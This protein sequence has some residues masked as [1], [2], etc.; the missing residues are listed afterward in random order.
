[1]VDRITKVH[2]ME[3]NY[4]VNK[5]ATD[6]INK[7]CFYFGSSLAER[8]NVTK[9]LIKVAVKAPI[10]LVD[11]KKIIFFPTKSPREKNCTWISYNN[12]SK[13]IKDGPR[14]TKIIFKNNSEFSLNV[15]Y[16]IIDNQITR[17]MKLEKELNKRLKSL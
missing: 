5:T 15:S 13:Y 10:I 4:F 11:S 3:T 2:E 14:K 7:S 1:M 8:Q 16:N 9:R 17:C 6:I 12:I